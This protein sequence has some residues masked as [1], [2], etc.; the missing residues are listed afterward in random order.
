VDDD[1]PGADQG[2]LPYLDADARRAAHHGA[3]F[4]ILVARGANGV[5]VFGEDDLRAAGPA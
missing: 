5:R 1:G 4:A 2:P 3:A